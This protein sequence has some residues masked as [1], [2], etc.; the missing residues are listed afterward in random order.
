MASGNGP[1]RGVIEEGVQRLDAVLDFSPALA[2]A[3]RLFYQDEETFAGPTF[4]NLPSRDPDRIE[5]ND[6]L[7]VTLTGEIYPPKAVRNLLDGDAGRDA[8]RWLRDMGSQP[9]W[10]RDIEAMHSS[11]DPVYCLWYTLLALDRVGPTK[12]SKLMARKRPDVVPM[13]D[14]VVEERIATV[15]DY[16]YVFHI[17]MSD[18]DRRKAVAHLRGQAEVSEVPLLRVL[19]TAVWILYSGGE[20]AQRV[21]QQCRLPDKY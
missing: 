2:S 5:P 15:D 12:A 16:W 3:V 21:R 10:E 17:F 9:L 13:Y 4:L 1:S 19:D 18:E 7:A 20:E 14:S 6:L 11:S 8:K